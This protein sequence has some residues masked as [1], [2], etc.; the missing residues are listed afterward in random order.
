[1]RHKDELTNEE[2]LSKDELGEMDEAITDSF[3]FDSAPSQNKFE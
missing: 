2:T 3:S 1:M